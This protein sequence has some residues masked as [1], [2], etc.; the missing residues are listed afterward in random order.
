VNGTNHQVAGA[1]GIFKGP[2]VAD[3]LE[4]LRRL[5]SDFVI[6]I[7]GLKNCSDFMVSI[8]TAAKDSQV[9]INFRERSQQHKD[10]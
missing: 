9:E 1:I 4:G 6:P 3:E 10:A 8:R 5:D 2:T 7:D